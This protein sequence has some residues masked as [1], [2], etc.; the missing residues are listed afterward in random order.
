MK[1]KLNFAIAGGGRISD[2]H[3]PGYLKSDKAKL[4]AVC[5][6]SKEVCEKRKKEWELEK[7][8][9]DFNELL[10]DK[11]IDA[12]E[13]LTPHH[14]HYP[15][16][17]KAAMAGKHISVQKPMALTL[18]ECDEMISVC[19]KAGVIFKVFENF[20]F[21]PPYVR[22]KEIMEKGDIGEPLCIRTRI[23]SGYGGWEVPLRAWA[24]RLNEAESGGGPTVFDDGYHKLSI[25]VDFFGPV[26]S[27]TGWIET[28]LGMID[29][30]VA[31]SWKHKSG[32]LGYM[33]AAMTPNL[34]VESKYY[35]ADE[36]VEIT[37][38]KGT[39]IIPH[40]TGQ[41][42]EA[43]PLTVVKENRVES[44]T[45]LRYD[46]IE[47]FIDSVQDFIDAV[48]AG[49]EPKLTGERGRDVTA[50]ALGAIEASK[51]QTT[52]WLETIEKVHK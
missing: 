45:D 21:Y 9:T 49:R 42:F 32:K 26:E 5:D 10:E 7:T 29:S 39:I 36:R 33:D 37:G 13:I 24:W 31:L 25:A 1:K 12:V 44:H 16:V 27:V 40:C 20:V 38:S 51:K 46:W 6:V 23:G 2:L 48:L 43:P 17:I 35:S 50:F 28:S 3:A 11:E 19:R 41:L 30:P 15:M 52:V 4:Y 22:A 34:Y 8:Y 47:S 14:L 18:K